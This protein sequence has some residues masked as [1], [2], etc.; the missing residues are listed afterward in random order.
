MH[1]FDVSHTRTL[2]VGSGGGE[3][4]PI[5][6]S[7]VAI[8][9]LISVCKSMDVCQA[10][11]RTRQSSGYFLRL[12]LSHS[13]KNEAMLCSSISSSAL[14]EQMGCLHEKSMATALIRLP[15]SRK[16]SV[17][18]ATEKPACVVLVSFD[19]VASLACTFGSNVNPRRRFSAGGGNHFPRLDVSATGVGP[20]CKPND[21]IEYTRGRDAEDGVLHWFAPSVVRFISP[22][23]ST[24]VSSSNLI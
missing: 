1:F 23:Y 20:C 21:Q 10:M 9:P 15:T 18:S 11:H 5:I 24:S 8:T 19:A 12:S 7:H 16:P 22:L 4:A 14:R 3:H 6:T 2:G 17:S 13:A